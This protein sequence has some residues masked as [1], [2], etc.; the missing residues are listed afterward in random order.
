MFFIQVSAEPA[1]Y[2]HSS[3]LLLG[4]CASELLSSRSCYCGR[5]VWHVAYGIWH[6]AYGI[7]LVC[8]YPYPYLTSAHCATTATIICQIKTLT[9]APS[10]L[11]QVVAAGRGSGGRVG[12]K[13]SAKAGDRLSSLSL[14][15]ATVRTFILPSAARSVAAAAVAVA[16]LIIVAEVA[17]MSSP[18]RLGYSLRILSPKCDNV[19]RGKRQARHEAEAEALLPLQFVFHS[20]RRQA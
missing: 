4:V 18:R 7:C 2:A 17:A 19:R 16:A 13:C 1:S 10:V 15:D 14:T 9:S 12:C 11:Q 5:A 20:A 8:S 3:Y 6:M